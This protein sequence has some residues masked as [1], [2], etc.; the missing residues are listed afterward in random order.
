MD[1]DNTLPGTPSDQV[2]EILRTGESGIQT[3]F[4]SLARRHP[5]GADAD[6]LRWH[7]LDHRPEQ[8]RLPGL[9]ASLRV[10]STPACRAA[11]AASVGEYDE[12]DHVM[13]YFFAGTSDLADFLELSDALRNAGRSPFILP[14][15]ARGVY[16]VS[17]RQA[18]PRARVGADVLPWLPMRGVYVLIEQGEAPELPLPDVEGVAGVWR[19]DSADSPYASIESGQQLSLCFLDADPVATAGRL[20]PLLE[21]RWRTFAVQPLLA[22]P[23]QVISPYEWERYLP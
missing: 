4:L 5:D 17:S 19:A 10:V 16:K 8:H 6:Y 12:V 14:P 7:S 9:R 13:H 3:L 22:A 1:S 21:S 23:F 15:V 18:A 20:A 2:P 11:R